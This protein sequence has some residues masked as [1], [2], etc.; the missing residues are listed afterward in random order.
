MYYHLAIQDVFNARAQI[1]HSAF[2]ALTV[3]T[4]FH[5]P[6]TSQL[7]LVHHVP[8]LATVCNATQLLPKFASLAILEAHWL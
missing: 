3:F 4:W 8:Y 2:P 5:Q 1:H 6:I 7:A